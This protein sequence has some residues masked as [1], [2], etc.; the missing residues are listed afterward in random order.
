MTN[1]APKFFS[2]L[3]TSTAIAAACISFGPQAMAGTD[4]VGNYDVMELENTAPYEK[5]KGYVSYKGKNIVDNAIQEDIGRYGHTHFDADRAVITGAEAGT[6]RIYGK[7]SATGD[8]Y[9]LD[10]NGFLFGEGSTVDITGNFG[11][12]AGKVDKED[13]LDGDGV[14]NVETAKGGKIVIEEG[15]M[16]SVADAG[17]AAF[18]APTIQNAGVINARVGKVAFAAGE[19]VTIDLYGDKLVEIAVDDKLE[20][21][22]IEH[23][24]VINAQGGTVQISAQAAKQAVDNI[25]N[26]DGV[27]NVTS[28]TQQGGK[29]V[30][31]G[32]DQGVVNVAG[33]LNANGATGGQVDV[34]GQNVYVA[35]GAE[36]S[37][38]GTGKAGTVRV[39]GDYLGEG[40]LDTAEQVYVAEGSSISAKSTE[41][42][43]GGKVIVWSD[44]NTW[45]NGDIDA[46]GA[47]GQKGGFVETSGKENLSLHGSVDAGDEGEWLL[48]PTDIRIVDGAG[49]GDF[50]DWGLFTGFHYDGDGV[51]D[52]NVHSINAALNGNSHVTLQTNWRNSN[53]GNITVD[54]DIVKSSGGTATLNL[55]AHNDLIVNANITSTSGA[56]NVKLDGEAGDVINNGTI[57]TNGGW[58][59]LEAGNRVINSGTINSNGGDVQL[60]ALG[61]VVNNGAVTTGGGVFGAY[62]GYRYDIGII[63]GDLTTNSTVRTTEDSEI[64][65]D[66]GKATFRATKNI[67]HNGTVLT[68]GGDV[69][70]DAQNVITNNGS[71]VTDGGNV[72]FDAGRIWFFDTNYNARI[73][74]NADSLINTGPGTVTFVT[75]G[76]ISH[77]GTIQT[78]TGKVDL[79]NESALV[80]E[81]GSLISTTSGNVKLDSDDSVTHGGTI[82]TQDGN[83][84][85]ES[86]SLLGLMTSNVKTEAGSHIETRGGD[87]TLVG[88]GDVTHAGQIITDGGE[89]KL[90]AGHYID[91]P[92]VS[93]EVPVNAAAHLK[94]EA[95]SIVNSG[96]GKTILK[97]QGAVTHNGGVTATSGDVAVTSVTGNVNIVG[98]IA[99]SGNVNL[100]AD[101]DLNLNAGSAITANTLTVKARQI[102]QDIAGQIVATT[103]TGSSEKATTLNGTTNSIQYLTDFTTGGSDAGG[104]VL[105]N[106]YNGKFQVKGDVSSQ[107]GDIAI[108]NS[109]RL[110][111][112]GTGSVVSNGGDVTLTARDNSMNIRGIVNAGTGDVDLDAG[113][114]INLNEGTIS[115]DTVTLTGKT[116]SQDTT[117]QIIATTLT[118]SS[119]KTTTLN[120]ADNSI[121][122]LDDFMTGEVSGHD[123]GFVL[124]NDYTTGEGKFRV[125][126]A[127]SSQGGDIALINTKRLGVDTS[128]SILS[129]GGNITLTSVN[130]LLYSR[131][132]VNA[133]DGDV[134]LDSGSKISLTDGLVKGDTVS[135]IANGPILQNAGATLIATALTGS[136][137]K[138]TELLGANNEVQSI[139]DFATG[140]VSGHDGGFILNNAYAG[141]LNVTG[142]VSSQGGAITITTPGALNVNGASHASVISNGGD[143]T[144]TSGGWLYAHSTINAGAGDVALD[145]GATIRLAGNVTGEEVTLTANNN[146]NQAGGSIIATTLTGSS[147]GWTNL[148]SAANSVQ[149][150]DDFSTGT[151]SNV[152]GFVLNNGY[153]GK[154]EIVGDVTSQGGDIVITTAGAL[155]VNGADDASVVSNGGNITLTSGGWLYAHNTIN[156]GTG[157]VALDSGATIRLAG[158]VTGNEL[159]LTAANNIN[160]AGGSITATTLTGSSN[161]WTNLAGGTNSVQYLN[162]FS[163]GTASNIGGF[164]LDNDYNGK[165]Q[166]KGDVSS[167]GGNINVENSFRL[168][169]D[170]TGSVVSNGG[171]IALTAR[172]N[173]MNIRGLVDAG[174]G[175][176]DLEAG[177]AINLNEGTVSGDTVTLTGKVISQDATGTLIANTLTGSSEKQTTLVGTNNDVANLDTF[178]TGG[179]HEGGFT[180]N[181]SANGLNII[182]SVT[183]QGGD[184]DVDVVG[185]LN[186][187]NGGLVN[188]NGGDINLFQTGYFHSVN[189][190]TVITSGTGDITLYQN[191]GGSIQNAINAF[192]NTGTGTNTLYVGPGTFNEFVTV[193]LALDLLGAQHGVDARGRTGAETIITPVDNTDNADLQSS[194]LTVTVDGAGSKIDGFTFNAFVPQSGNLNGVV[195]VETGADN[196]VVTNNIFNTD[197]NPVG[198]QGNMPR[199]LVVLADDSTI[200]YNAFTRTTDALDQ[201]GNISNATIRVTGN[202]T[203]IQHNDVDGG[204][205]RVANSTGTILIDDNDVANT[206]DRHGIEVWGTDGTI[207]I[208]NNDLDGTN[209]SGI[210]VTTSSGDLDIS[211][212]TV[213]SA[214]DGVANNGIT[215]NDFD[216]AAITGNTLWGSGSGV[217]I[218]VVDSDDTTVTSNTVSNFGTGIK[219]NSSEDVKVEL[220]T[221]NDNTI[222]VRVLDSDGVFVGGSNAAASKNT[223]TGGTTGV[224]A[225]GSDSLTVQENEISGVVN[226]VL[227][228]GTSGSLVSDIL[229]DDNDI[230]DF[231]GTGVRFNYVDGG[232]IFDNL[233]N[234]STGSVGIRVNN[235]NDIDVGDDGNAFRNRIQNVKTGV[236]VNASTDVRL[237]DND[238]TN[239]QNYGIQVIGGSSNIVVEDHTITGLGGAGNTGIYVNGSS[240]VTVGGGSGHGNDISGFNTGIRVANS[241]DSE[242]SNNELDDINNVNI[243]VSNSDGTSLVDGIRVL[244]NDIDGGKTG[245]QMT[246]SD[247]ATVDGNIIKNLTA[248][249]IRFSGSTNG[250]ITNNDIDDVGNAGILL[251]DLSNDTLV[252]DNNINGA[253]TGIAVYGT[254]ANQISGITIDDNDILDFDSSAVVLVNA[255][256]SAVTDNVINNASNGSGGNGIY[257]TKSHD[258]VIGGDDAANRN[259]VHNNIQNVKNAITVVNSNDVIVGQNDVTN[260]TRGIYAGNSSNITVKD[261]VLTSGTGNAIQFSNVQDSVI[262]GSDTD[263]NEITGYQN[264]IVINGSNGVEA[265]W[266]DI[267]DV[268]R[269][270]IRIVNSDGT[271]LGG[272]DNVVAKNNEITGFGRHGI[273]VNNSDYA[274]IG[275]FT[276]LDA[277]IIDGEN[278]GQNGITL[279]SADNAFVGWNSLTNLLND[280]VRGISSNAAN[281]F[282]NTV[283]NTGNGLHFISSSNVLLDTNTVTDVTLDGIQVTG[284]TNNTAQDNIIERAGE[285]GIDFN[286]SNDLL[287]TGNTVTES[288]ESGIDV[289][290]IIGGTIS[291]NTA[292]DNVLAGVEITGSSDIDVNGGNSASGNEVGIYADTSSV[293][294]IDG[295]TTNQ[296]DIGIY[297]QDVTNSLITSSITNQ[298]TIAGIKL[299]RVNNV[300]VVN[301]SQINENG[302]YGLWVAEAGSGN[303]IVS[304]NTFIDNPTA[305]RAESGAIDISSLVNPNTIINT[306]PLNTPVGIQLDG[307][308]VSLVGNTLGGTIFSGFTTP[309]SYYV[310][311]EDGTLLDPATGAPV[312]INGLNASFDGFVPASQGGLLTQNDLDFLEARIYDADDSPLNGRGN[313]FLGQVPTADDLEGLGNIEDFFNAFGY[314]ITALAGLNVRII[315]LPS[316]GGPSAA[317]LNNLAPAAGS[318]DPNSLNNITPAAGG[319]E[320]TTPEDLNN[321]N[322]EAGGD[323]V[324]CWSDAVA[325]GSVATL[326]Y[327]GTMEDALDTAD[328]C[329]NAG[330]I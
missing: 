109:F 297:L 173:S 238:I 256:N 211:G 167:Q 176:V 304:G 33:K 209:N 1:T 12:F 194:L 197:V 162:D 134:T 308:D 89:A 110:E 50:G 252:Q 164:V 315:G 63:T 22:L 265:S 188:A 159:T 278:V 100:D 60:V 11:A 64:N 298:N 251:R 117:G 111:I 310:R 24:G 81:A 120:G 303:V 153:A 222:G 28:A 21:A 244:D 166:I 52:V 288:G 262:G 184:V 85:L 231:T 320:G 216:G 275:G 157:N 190:E 82:L 133:E 2:K 10:V 282:N 327:G 245:I 228:Q 243:Y 158:D 4:A 169:V 221:L 101:D 322:T 268:T 276:S 235:S 200:T 170:G 92:F 102:S 138:E 225:S 14:F 325:G 148:A 48:D 218:N 51:F 68:D 67:K 141:T 314:P 127:V 140:E 309:G 291:D 86:D 185:N 175:D 20:D 223:I 13:L 203:T 248:N 45:M 178:T 112:D 242:I 37:A 154:L 90:L 296:N 161:G 199:E 147:N 281:I 258:I 266:N 206:R 193:D 26:L 305:I 239:V 43:E 289:S 25:I 132:T 172:D 318:T 227:V 214:T 307:P 224:L 54:A 79:D 257:V 240:N 8:L 116:I 142:D 230:T 35:D 119:E 34:T 49:D 46:S 36:I 270:G 115:G 114:S 215:V 139:G 229:V 201:A 65:T 220:N 18:V 118:G 183:T 71:V 76:T 163:T 210:R 150:L 171:D 126:G 107:G 219:V 62:A 274:E 306:N 290:N 124:N 61:N 80:T 312:Q 324:T 19:K 44:K 246:N 121:E 249:G 186:I 180:L 31:S 59:V 232:D 41:D 29:I 213:G 97:S 283:S 187:A 38:D 198:P 204:P 156:A 93:L 205:I 105:N 99:T 195:K 272:T 137:T 179:T 66:G 9:L 98:T 196:V 237:D 294:T 260:T 247:F 181:D 155:S 56:L 293:I 328:S 135:L 27:V 58:A 217:G 311:F 319:S 165:F 313:V 233:I 316:V 136:S 160:Q 259:T 263:T 47:E 254:D 123:G 202:N 326:T 261:N 192:L 285:D 168:E 7:L 182:G 149:Y 287:I 299:V 83:V 3:I 145:S 300:S 286:G 88:T 40:D 39:G 317:G 208:S 323:E 108:E 234:S 55:D 5:S 269:D 72:E 103:L 23:S 106:A 273:Y 74:T 78:T 267:E 143:I 87:V 15:A 302:Q 279:V 144:L 207:T 125:V 104:F 57:T 77:G 264:G 70:F 226:G 91:T 128:G 271:S 94:T 42:G 174:S 131:G 321:I 96:S 30:L 241:T 255:F 236:I 329:S 84:L 277:N 330:A 17:L 146:I 295:N 250:E 53:E 212:N 122:Y 284:G 113:T 253:K 129:N 16:I 292:N 191:V 75:P 73:Q 152:G 69:E 95:G 177:T 6:M 301:N 151:A 32:G 280:G 130:D 189:E